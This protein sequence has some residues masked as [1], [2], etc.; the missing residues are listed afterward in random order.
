[1]VIC[2]LEGFCHVL[3]H[4]VSAFKGIVIFI[5]VHSQFTI[6]SS[7]KMLFKCGGGARIIEF[8]LDLYL[9]NIMSDLMTMQ[10]HM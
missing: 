1:M 6:T 8:I 2:D 10:G 4:K 7:Y 9:N 5:N 3:S